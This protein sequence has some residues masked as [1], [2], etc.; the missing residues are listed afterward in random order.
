[1]GR[2]YDYLV[3]SVNFM[4]PGCLKVIG[5]R[6]KM[7]GGK[8]VLIVTDKFLRN[9][10]NGA[11]EQTIKYL[12]EA[13]LEV[14]IY[15]GTEPNPKDTNVADGLKVF[16]DKN[17][18]MIITVGGGS[19]HDC[20]KGIGIAAT[21]EG[22]LYEYA[23]I[24][25]LTNALPPILAV[26][27]TAGTG[28]EV[29]RHCVIT[30]TKTKVKYVIVSW[31][32]LPLV[33]FNDP[34][35]MVGKPAGLT[36]ATGMDALTHAVEA[37]VSKDA[38]PV[39]DASA[40]QSIKLISNNLR[41]AVAMGENLEARTNMAYASLLAGMAFNNANL[42]YVHAMAHQL[43]G[44]YD[45]PHGVANAMLLPHVCKYNI[46]SN[47]QK[48][49]DIA[50]FMGENIDGLS[51]HEAAEK[52]IDAMF[53][54]SKDIGIPTSLKEMG[55]KEEDFEYMAEMALKDGNAFSNP[56]KGNKQDIINIFKA[57]Y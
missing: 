1:M 48:F 21:H 54:L 56:R 19:S 25:T 49:A 43:G 23:G 38:N 15:D 31:R 14:V 11:V 35:L 9:Q 16:K 51:V 32:N 44:L 47:P 39:T 8:K 3:P 12:T 57:A 28:S 6:A 52:A 45:M 40:I 46:I 27:T 41:Q 24:E 36:A 53:R 7:L 2:M 37:Y 42:G 17:C 55:I 20:G 29:T 50:E 22:D 30:N 4:G 34:E 26:N 13:G 33:S 5:E 18:D 10:E